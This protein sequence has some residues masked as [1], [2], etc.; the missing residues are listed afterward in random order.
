MLDLGTDDPEVAEP[1]ARAISI[2]QKQIAPLMQRES[3]FT[4]LAETSAVYQLQ[5]ATGTAPLNIDTVLRM[6]LESANASLQQIAYFIEHA[7]KIDRITLQS[8][9]R[10]AILGTAR[11]A[12]V[13]LPTDPEKRL[14]NAKSV[15]AQDCQSGIRGIQ[16][17]VEFAGMPA[18]APSPELLEGLRQ[19]K[20]ELYPK[21]R[22]PGEATIIHRQT[23]ALIEALHAAGID[24]TFSTDIMRDHASW[25]WNTYSGLAHAN[26][27]PLL[28][29]GIS[30]DRRIP[31][32]FPID[33]YMT[34]TAFH[35]A[36]LAYLDRTEAGSAF[37]TEHVD[38]MTDLT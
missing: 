24:K 31:G 13:L 35:M 34:T 20:D 30:P 23:E 21:G 2:V 25:L 17:Y 36:V 6:A 22:L 7:P 10:V 14:E 32:D 9:M 8:L 5:Q 26:S 11:T 38:A 18:M 16:Q 37:T 29:P 15:I 28:L 1:L 19:Q 3:L 33:L 27:W 4:G 12:F